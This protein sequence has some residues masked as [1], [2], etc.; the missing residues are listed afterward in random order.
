M[1]IAVPFVG[2]WA[3]HVAIM[4]ESRSAFKM[5]TGKTTGKK[6]FREA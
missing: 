4:E 2:T 3:G 1:Y 5:L 6:N